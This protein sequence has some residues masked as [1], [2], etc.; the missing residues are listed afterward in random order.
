[1]TTSA[2][3]NALL[4]DYADRGSERAFAELVRRHVNLVYSAALR[5]CAGDSALAEEITQTVF[6]DLARKARSLPREVVVAGW[7]Y[8]HASFVS[9]TFVRSE[10]RRR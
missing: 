3:S 8:R 4:H 5:R 10:S 9:A 2:E 6:T 1:M 7:L